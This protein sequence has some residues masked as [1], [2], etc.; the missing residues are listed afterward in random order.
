MLLY[1]SSISLSSHL[2]VS[3]GASVKVM[4]NAPIEKTFL[5]MWLMAFPRTW[6]RTVRRQRRALKKYFS[7]IAWNRATF[8][9]EV[10]F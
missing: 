10:R 2:F 5:C 3:G 1:T 9:L 4:G 8:T 6:I 7:L